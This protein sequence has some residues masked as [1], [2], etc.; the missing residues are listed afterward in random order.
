MKFGKITAA[1]MIAA[2]VPAVSA[3]AEITGVEYTPSIGTVTVNGTAGAGSEAFINVLLGSEGA[4]GDRLVYQEVAEADGENGYSISF[5][6][7]PL[8]ITG[9]SDRLI[10][11]TENVGGDGSEYKLAFSDKSVLDGLKTAENKEQYISEN[12][13]AL[14]LYLNG[15]DEAP[16][17][18]GIFNMM[19][20]SDYEKSCDELQKTLQEYMLYGYIT[21]GAVSDLFAY[22]ETLGLDDMDSMNEVFT[23]DIFKETNRRDATAR[24][25]GKSFDSRE[26]FEKHLNEACVLAVVKSP[27]GYGNVKKVLDAFEDEIGI[28]AS[29]GTQKVYTGL[30]NRD[31]ENYAELKDAYN[32]LVSNTGNTGSGGSGG[33]SGGGSGGSGGSG[34]GGGMPAYNPE[35]NKNPDPVT[36]IHGES[37]MDMEGYDWASEAVDDLRAKGIVQGKADG[38]F[39]P[40]DTVTRSEFVKMAVGAF[41]I[42]EIE[43]EVPFDDIDAGRWDYKY[44]CSAYAA[45]MITGISDTYFGCGEPVTRQ[46]MAVMIDRITKSGGGELAARF[47][48]DRLITEYAYE[49]VYD[50]KYNGIVNG[51]DAN[52]FNPY[53][54]ATRAEAAVMIYR[55]M[56]S[57]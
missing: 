25:K 16:D 49:A 54:N 29:K 7:E 37:F 57:L 11:I 33:S 12:R 52:L 38:K 6:I 4:F 8:L 22:G 35:G 55:A 26:E 56:Q 23:D 39:C 14:G 28:D 32:K 41:A 31:F 21:E 30:Q 27:D 42:G 46:D 36:E 24:M 48:D 19:T 51:D 20:D 18:N 10:S 50:L 47:E 5:D 15:I 17:L 13:Y 1:L 34:G 44:I 3:S 9:D 45:G 53:S 43:A 40:Q 2:A